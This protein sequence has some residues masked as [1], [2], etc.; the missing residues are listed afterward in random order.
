MK[1]WLGND[2]DVGDKVIYAT[3]YGHLVNMVLAE[4]VGIFKGPKYGYAGYTH[5]ELTEDDKEIKVKLQP[6][7]SSRW[8]QHYGRKVFTD[9]RTGE[10]IKNPYDDIR[11]V[12]WDGSPNQPFREYVK[13]T[14]IIKPVVIA[15]TEN[16]VKWIGNELQRV[17]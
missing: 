7:K 10:R 17:P 1:D 16:I 4:V 3:M 5:R 9:I 8:K 2:Y 14:N 12:G 11:Y 6:L 13:V 15:V